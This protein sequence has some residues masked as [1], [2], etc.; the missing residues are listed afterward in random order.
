[1]NTDEPRPR[2]R[3]RKKRGYTGHN[4]MGVWK[5]AYADFVT[6][7]MAFFMVMWLLTQ[8]DLKL[9]SQIAMY[10]RS[11]GVLPGGAAINEEM[12]AA[13]SRGPKI[14]S[15]DIV[16][17]QGEGEERMLTGRAKEIEREVKQA[18]A[19]QP[20]MAKIVEQVHVD[21]TPEGLTIEVIDQAGT[22][23]FDV[24]SAEL[25]PQVVAV[26]QTIGPVLA[27]LP[28]PIQIG[29]HTDGRPFP[30]G[31]PMTNWQLAF[32]RADN[33]RRV[34]EASGLRP[35]QIE[36]VLSFADTK[37]LVPENPLADEN[38][39]LSILAVRRFPQ[40]EADEGGP[41]TDELGVP[42]VPPATPAPAVPKP[43]P[44][45]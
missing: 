8:A 24:S 31:S 42:V 9:R 30:A 5:L 18:A 3:Y 38:R 26:L 40:P 44:R 39:R 35:G 7:M 27:K 34:L 37:P 12:N 28:N 16:V 20:E 15:N 41:V 45:R 22:L 2:P 4:R 23:L 25:K 43:E 10:F 11:P 13:R 21:V 14:V 29:G 33:A 17:V 32:H 1:V 36:R 19:E 6:A